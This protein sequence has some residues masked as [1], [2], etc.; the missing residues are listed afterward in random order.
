MIWDQFCQF[1]KDVLHMENGFIICWF[2]R[3]WLQSQKSLYQGGIHE[4]GPD[5][6]ILNTGLFKQNNPPF[7]K[8]TQKSPN[9]LATFV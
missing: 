6:S 8:I 5:E 7:L 9:V 1:N 3:L 2:Q 4:R